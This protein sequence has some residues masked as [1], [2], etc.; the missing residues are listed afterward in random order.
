MSSAP[1]GDLKTVAV[2][3]R[4]IAVFVHEE[5]GGI[6][7]IDL[8]TVLM[9]PEHLA[10][11][12]QCGFR[13][14][15]AVPRREVLAD[16]VSTAQR[17]ERDTGTLLHGESDDLFFV[18]EDRHD[19]PGQK[20]LLGSRSFQFIPEFEHGDDAL[21]DAIEF[22]L[23]VQNG[24]LVDLDKNPVILRHGI[25]GSFSAGRNNIGTDEFK[26]TSI[27]SINRQPFFDLRR[28][29]PVE[30]VAGPGGSRG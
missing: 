5:V 22:F 4:N 24:I 28:N 13:Q 21:P 29:G 11:K 26:R 7:V 8:H 15:L 14:L 17:P 23:I 20:V 10:D 27:G 12:V 25:N 3:E 30:P 2:D 6:E 18:V 1:L 19:G 16:T 9:Q